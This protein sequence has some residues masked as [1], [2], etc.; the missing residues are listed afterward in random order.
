MESVDLIVNTTSVGLQG[1]KFFPMAYH[2]TNRRCLFFDMVY[3]ERTDFQR[4]AARIGRRTLDGTS[5]LLYQGAAAFA[6]WTGRRAPLAV[7]RAA[8]TMPRD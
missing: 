1:E 3:G 6:L 4:A 2:A 5:L 8:V 7:M